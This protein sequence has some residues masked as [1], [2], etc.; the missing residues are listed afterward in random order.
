M[1]FEQLLGSAA[2]GY[3]FALN[4]GLF[5]TLFMIL[6]AALLANL[7]NFLYS[8][9]MI[10]GCLADWLR[11]GA[12]LVGILYCRRSSPPPPSPS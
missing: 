2:L 5:L 8:M 3:S 4:A 7:P 12:L 6:A 1:A 11:A 9:P 10:P